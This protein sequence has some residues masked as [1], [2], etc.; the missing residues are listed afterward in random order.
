MVFA[1][2]EAFWSALLNFLTG[3]SVTY[4]YLNGIFCI[5]VSV[6]VYKLQI[7]VDNYGQ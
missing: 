3:D 4:S 1:E 6:L 7:S 5:K 2:D